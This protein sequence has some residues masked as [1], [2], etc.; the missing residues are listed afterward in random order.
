MTMNVVV[1][2]IWDETREIRC[3]ELSSVGGA[4]PE[5]EPGAH[6]EVQLR[7]DMV[8]HYSLWNGPEDKHAYLI[9]VKREQNGRGG[10]SAMHSLAVGETIAIS[11]PRNNFSLVDC[12]AR[13]IMLAGGIGITPLLAMARLQEICGKTFVLHFFARDVASAPFLSEIAKLSNAPVHLGLF[14]PEL[15]KVLRGI[16]IE[17]DSDAHIYLCGPGPFMDLVEKQASICGWST[18]QIHLERF[19]ADADDILK[20]GDSFE[21]VLR[22]SGHVLHV[23]PEQTII[24]A[25][26]QAG[27]H[28]LTSCEQGVCGTCLTTVIE[29]IPDHNDCYLSEVEKLGGKL[30]TPCVSRCKGKRLVLDL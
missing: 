24:E 7:Q 2:R 27:L 22:R 30:I 15:D 10:S 4:L 13:S 16:L 3:F 12:Q 14:P 25:M 9:G 5:F 29:G 20:D 11:E 21:V 6:I 8:R 28:P 26:E 18:D 1:S 19:S 23:G 17:P